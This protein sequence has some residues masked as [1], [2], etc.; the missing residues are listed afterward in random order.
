MMDPKVLIRRFNTFLS[1]FFEC[2]MSTEYPK[3]AGKLPPNLNLPPAALQPLGAGFLDR[4]LLGGHVFAG[5]LHLFV[6]FDHGD[7]WRS[8]ETGAGIL[9]NPKRGCSKRLMV[10]GWW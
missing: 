10:A 5:G 3:I 9:P 6:E 4:C 1:W 2:Y 8:G 7:S